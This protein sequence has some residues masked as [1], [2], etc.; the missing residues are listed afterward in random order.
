MTA[1]RL[2]EERQRIG[3]LFLGV[4]FYLAINIASS[5]KAR[6]LQTEAS[7]PLLEQGSPINREAGDGQTHSFRVDMKAGEFLHVF[8]RQLGVNVGATLIAPDGTKV[9][10][11]DVPR[12]TQEPEWITHVAGPAGKYLIQVR[13]MDKGAPKGRY[14]ISI[15]E[16]RQRAAD[17]ET[18]LAAQRSFADGTQLFNEKN[19]RGSVEKYEQAL[20]LYRQSGRKLEQAVT[21]NCLARSSA[22]LYD[23][24]TTIA[25]SKEALSIYHDVGDV[26]G[27]GITL[28]GSEVHM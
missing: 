3:L 6:A 26:H 16:K 1:K 19:Y 20:A 8:I 14:E 18:R 28:K 13:T 22:S 21:L 15:D 17:D 27:E 9:L 10:E 2:L 24:Q 7:G 5:D 25:R 23:Y 12:S 11:A 4:A